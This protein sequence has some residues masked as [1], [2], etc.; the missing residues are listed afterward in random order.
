ML[1]VA[2]RG[3]EKN[4]KVQASCSLALFVVQTANISVYQ[5]EL[6]QCTR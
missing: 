1:E 4:A 3:V 5:R 6:A 2:G